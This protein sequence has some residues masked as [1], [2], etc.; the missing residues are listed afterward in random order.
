MPIA[1][2][3]LLSRLYAGHPE[4]NRGIPAR[5]LKG[6]FNGIRRLMLGMTI[7]D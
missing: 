2:F 5:N 6:N 3:R 4:R 1:N 7:S